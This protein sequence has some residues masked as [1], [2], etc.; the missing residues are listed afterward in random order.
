LL[1][2][3]LF[4]AAGARIKPNGA[5]GPGAGK[6]FQFRRWS[7]DTVTANVP[8]ADCTHLFWIDNIPVTGDIV[9]LRQ[10]GVASAAECQ[11][12][13]GTGAD[14]FSIGYRAYHPNGVSNDDSFMYWHS[15]GWQR[16]LNGPTGTLAPAVSP[17]ADA[18]EGGPPAQS[19]SDSFLAMLH[20]PPPQNRCTFSVHLYVNAKH[21]NGAS[22]LSGYDYYETASF[23]LD[24]G[25]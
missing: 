12:M 6:Q 19:G 24:L 10:N 8:F 14:Q 11:F 13:T 20:A 15:I 3:E 23:A 17:T 21:W 2:L 9:D 16:G 4:D 22:R 5:T 1:V 7:S 18:G 25:P